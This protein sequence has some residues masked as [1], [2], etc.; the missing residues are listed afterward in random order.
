MHSVFLSLRSVLNWVVQRLGVQSVVGFRPNC[1]KKSTVNN[2]CATYLMQGAGNAGF[3]AASG[4]TASLSG[5]Q[6]L[7]NIRIW[8]P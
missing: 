6:G 4:L 3:D 2:D 8:C 5:L 7:A 1:L